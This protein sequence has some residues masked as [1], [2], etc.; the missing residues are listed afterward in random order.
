M[1]TDLSKK[2]TEDY[3]TDGY[4]P[5][6]GYYFTDCAF[7]ELKDTPNKPAPL[8][9][10]K[11]IDFDGDKWCKVQIDDIIAEVK[12]FYLYADLYDYHHTLSHI[13][14]DQL[15]CDLYSIKMSEDYDNIKRIAEELRI[16]ACSWEPNVKLL[17]N[18]SAKDIEYLC[19]YI[20]YNQTG[21]P[22]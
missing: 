18:V 15:L 14:R 6:K 17:G 5:T 12:Y 10:V 21:T 3:N 16:C 4:T 8:R 11:L 19:D 20:I 9:K 7:V 13:S 22:E 2:M 1:E